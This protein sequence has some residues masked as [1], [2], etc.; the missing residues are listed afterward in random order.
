MNILRY[1]CSHKI[2]KKLLELEK[3]LEI[4]QYRNT[5]H[6]SKPAK[7]YK[8]KFFKGMLLQLNKKFQIPRNKSDKDCARPIYRK[9]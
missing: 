2:L 6:I 7:S 3:L 9:E 4:G 8:I 1:D 5:N